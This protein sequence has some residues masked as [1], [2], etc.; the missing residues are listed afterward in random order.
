LLQIN[1]KGGEAIVQDPDEAEA[2]S[3]PLAALKKVTAAKSMKLEEVSIF[4][5]LIK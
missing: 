3:M 1:K 5:Q 2:D 4:L